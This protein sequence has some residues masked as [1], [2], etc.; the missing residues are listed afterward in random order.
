MNSSSDLLTSPEQI[1]N[2]RL[3][4]LYVAC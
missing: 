1:L 2:I 4:H 3:M